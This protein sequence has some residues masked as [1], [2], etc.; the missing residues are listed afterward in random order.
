MVLTAVSAVLFT[1]AFPPWGQ[2]A[3]APLCLVP[4]LLALRS[5]S[6]ARAIGLAWLWG[7]AVAW[8]LAGAIPASIARFYEQPAWFG[9]VAG[10]LVFSVMST[11][12][13]VGFAVVD[14]WLVRRPACWTPLL[15]GATWVAAEWGRGRLFTGTSFFIGNPWGL[16]GYT[17]GAGALAQTAS[18]AGVY[19]IGFLLVVLNAG[20][21]ATIAY[22]YA[23]GRSSRDAAPS[24]GVTLAIA[25]LPWLLGTLAGALVLRAAP[26]LDG[27]RKDFR[28][29]AVVQGNVALG[30]RWRAD[31]YARNLEAYLGLTRLAARRETIETVIWP[32]AAMTFFV[33]SDRRLRE[34]I[35]GT[36]RAGDVELIAGG[37]HAA[38]DAPRSYR[39]SMFHFDGDGALRGRYDKTYLV[40]FFESLPLADLDFS[41][42]SFEGPRTFEP[43]PRRPEPLETRLGAAGL[44]VCVEAMFPEAA[45]ARVQAG[46]EILVNPSNDGWVA[47]AGFAEHMLAVVALRAIEQRRYLVRAST[48]GPSAIIDP[49]GRIPVRTDALQRQILV[50]RVRPL[51]KASVYQRLGDA[52][53]YAGMLAVLL[54][55]LARRRPTGLERRTDPDPPDVGLR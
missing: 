46:A 37:P 51:Q 30:R 33:E 53:A 35:T 2:R 41:K 3:L 36:L 31:F 27:S 13:Y 55:A 39:N 14:R 4:L 42:R 47:D 25:A 18:V 1:L 28:E 32:E 12:Y 6:M 7:S 34:S 45:A 50:G 9:F 21:A 19:G 49:W 38:D 48:T 26:P 11:V 40:P 5:G 44:L 43:G 23:R 54:V 16:I 17:H 29:V 22:A 15:V 8:M 24:P 10:N 52:P 20:V